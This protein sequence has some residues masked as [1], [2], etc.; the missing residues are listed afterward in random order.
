MN[1]ISSYVTILSIF[2]L[3]ILLISN[4]YIK[5]IF[6]EPFISQHLIYSNSKNDNSNKNLTD[7][8]CD[9]LNLCD[10]HSNVKV[11][12]ILL[13]KDNNVIDISYI[14]SY[15]ELPFPWQGTDKIYFIMYTAFKFLFVADNLSILNIFS[16][17]N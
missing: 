15:L 7:T 3:A 8:E 10:N 2:F 17:K 12:G 9:F 1:T 16:S 4:Y 13:P 14:S 6:S 11:N 5:Y